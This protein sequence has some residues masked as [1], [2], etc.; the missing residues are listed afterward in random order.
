MEITRLF[1]ILELYRTKYAGKEDAFAKNV[2]GKW[3][4]YSAEDYIDLSTNVSYGLLELGLEKGDRVA[5]ISQNRPEWN[6]LDMGIAQA[7]LVHVPIY[8]TISSAEQEYILN[9]CEAKV[10]CVSDQMLMK[11]V[12]S[13]LEKVPSL[14]AVYTYNEVEGEKHW[15][16]L[17]ELGESVAE[18]QNPTLEANKKD[19][20]PEDLITDVYVPVE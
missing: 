5:T 4:K 2:D 16:S 15:L 8:P 17:V 13:I 1:D 3:I 14:K 7:G 9:H 12:K 18:K 6:M 10:L 20:K 19:T 11:K